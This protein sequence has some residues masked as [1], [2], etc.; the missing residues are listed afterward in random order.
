MPRTS[1]YQFLVISIIGTGLLGAGLFARAQTVDELQQKISSKTS[2]I[3]K[4]EQ[5]IKQYQGD[6]TTLNAKKK[7]LKNAIA[8]LDATRKKLDTD[9][10]ITQTKVDTADI[11]IRQLDTEISYKEDQID[12]RVAALIEALRVINEQEAMSLAEVAL[13]RESFS[14]VWND[15]ETLGQ[16]NAEV[17]PNVDALKTLKSELEGK[18]TVQKIEKKNLLGLKSELGDRKKIADDNKK[19]TSQILAQTSNKESEYTKILNQKIALK[20][21]FEKEL[22]DYE[23]TL[24]FILDPTSIPPRGTKVFSAPLND[25]HITQ[26][27]GNTEFA[28]SGAYNGSGHNGVDF[29]T[30]VGTKVKSM[31]GGTVIGTGD[32]DITC[33]GASYGRWV[34]IKHNNGLASLYAH[35][36]LIKVSKNDVVST[37]DI[38]GYSGNTGYSTGPHLHLTV[39]AAAA[40]KIENRPSKACS[41]RTYTMPISAL[42]GYLNPLD[43][44]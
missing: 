22:H 31:L 4:L 43:Y 25:V 36:S 11:K 14:G 12:S 21:A 7:T 24:K 2:E 29:G 26:Y 18:H 39:F 10:R 38:I 19:A 16:F 42:N 13:S 5:E 41:G 17:A 15:L 32:T 44:L 33:P 9:L 40:V 35:L 20:D 23:S 1:L 6:I 27:F 28:K 37:G 8:V 34:L 3:Q 30:S